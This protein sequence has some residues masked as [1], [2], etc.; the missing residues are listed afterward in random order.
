M[1]VVF[2]GPTD[3]LEECVQA[4]TNTEKEQVDQ[5]PFPIVLDEEFASSAESVGE[6]WLG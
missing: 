1:I 4:A 3:H 6:I 2:P 5:V